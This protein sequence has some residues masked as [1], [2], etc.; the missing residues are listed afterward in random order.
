MFI[1]SLCFSVCFTSGSS[2]SKNGTGVG[3]RS[4]PGSA[5]AATPAKKFR[6]SSQTST[7]V[8][9][10]AAASTSAAASADAADIKKEALHKED[11]VEDD[12]VGTAAGDE[13]VGY[14]EGA[15]ADADFYDEGGESL[16]FDGDEAGGGGAGAGG[17][18]GPSD[19]GKGRHQT[20]RFQ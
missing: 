16:G 14:D 17:G 15:S 9:A 11:M 7:P 10:A 5:A 3:K 6:P 8:T 13:S 12:L 20:S 2:A 1:S 18:A 4:K 19:I